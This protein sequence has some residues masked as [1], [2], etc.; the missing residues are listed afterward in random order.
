MNKND[1]SLYN[2]TFFD[3][4]AIINELDFFKNYKEKLS[5]FDFNYL[6]DNL[7]IEEYDAY[8]YIILQGEIGT[9]MYILLSGN[10]SAYLCKNKALYKVETAQFTKISLNLSM[11]LSTNIVKELINRG[12]K[13]KKRILIQHNKIKFN[14]LITLNLFNGIFNSIMKI[15]KNN[16]TFFKD[17]LSYFQNINNKMLLNL[18]TGNLKIIPKRNKNV[19]DYTPGNYFGE[20]A[21]ISNNLV[22]SASVI[23]TTK[24]KVVYIKNTVFEKIIKKY[25]LIHKQEIESFLKK[26]SFFKY[27]EE[28]NALSNLKEF[29]ITKNYGFNEELYFINNDVNGL[30]LIVEGY[31]RL[32]ISNKKEN[33][34]YFYDLKSPN[35]TGE[36]EYI[37]KANKRISTAKVYSQKAVIMYI[38]NSVKINSY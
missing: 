2:I 18:Y 10:C 37:L 31:V 27:W 12:L 20:K 36:I 9:K 28:R 33:K 14:C 16:K 26:F 17:K 24:C 34:N 5:K 29:F 22:R 32:L 25:E 1:G 11:L 21:L 3:V 35:I 7:I 4:K 38:N 15:K 23:T 19:K 13:K 6:V 8:N 30:Y